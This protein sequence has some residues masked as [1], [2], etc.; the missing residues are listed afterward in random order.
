MHG[1]I[2]AGS[3][4]QD[5]FDALGTSKKEGKPTP[6]QEEGEATAN[7]GKGGKRGEPY[8]F[9]EPGPN[10]DRSQGGKGPLNPEIALQ[11]PNAVQAGARCAHRG[12]C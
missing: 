3:S 2:A 1:R 9:R 12:P 8:G 11:E 7:Q 5:G 6:G 10:S 4:F